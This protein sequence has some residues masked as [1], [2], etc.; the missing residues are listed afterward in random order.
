[1]ILGYHKIS[2]TLLVNAGSDHKFKRF[3]TKFYISSFNNRH[4]NL[5]PVFEKKDTEISNLTMN[6]FHLIKVLIKHLVIFIGFFK[7]F[8]QYAFSI[9]ATHLM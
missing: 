1:M 9:Y 6:L 8:F 2:V 5:I 3:V 4:I 7:Y